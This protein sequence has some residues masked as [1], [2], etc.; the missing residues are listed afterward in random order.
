M[1]LISL[2]GHAIGGQDHQLKMSPR[3]DEH[4]IH[5]FLVK[6]VPEFGDLLLEALTDFGKEHGIAASLPRHEEADGKPC[7]GALSLLPKIPFRVLDQYLV[8]KHRHPPEDAWLP[9]L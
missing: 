3:H 4:P 6:V 5:V 2:L 7:C 8:Q 9:C 1:D